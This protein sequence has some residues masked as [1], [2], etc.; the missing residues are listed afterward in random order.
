MTLVDVSLL[1]SFC[2][3]PGFVHAVRRGS[4]GRRARGPGRVQCTRTLQVTCTVPISPRHSALQTL[5]LQTLHLQMRRKQALWLLEGLRG[6]G[7]P[8]LQLEQYP[9]SAQLAADLAAAVDEAVHLPGKSVADLGCGPGV[10][11]AA[12]AAWGARKCTG[13]EV[14][15]DAVEVCRLNLAA[16]ADDL[17]DTEFSVRHCD[18]SI[19]VALRSGSGAGPRLR[20]R[21]RRAVRP[22][23]HEPAVRHQKQ[24]GRGLEV[25]AERAEPVEPGRT[26]ILSAQV[27][28]ARGDSAAERRVGGRGGR[29]G[30]GGAALGTSSNVPPP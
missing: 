27:V 10:L 2:A 29:R 6:F 4:A 26:S 9:T 28:D 15:A 18:V 7:T 24:R 1:R 13:F 8:K 14:D 19:D 22:G 20:G 3:A 23:G 5:H 11:M 25:R 21:R 30:A 17:P 16:L 12:C